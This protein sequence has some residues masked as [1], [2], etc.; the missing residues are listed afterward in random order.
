MSVSSAAEWSNAEWSNHVGSRVVVR[1]REDGGFRDVLGELLAVDADTLVV[2]GRGGPQRLA[3]ADV[4]AGKPV[5]PRAT[6]RAPA[7]LGLSVADLELV[8]AKHWQ[9][10][11]QEWLGGWLLRADHGFTR[12]ANSVLAIGEPGMQLDVAALEVWD[13][14]HERGL[15]PLAAAPRPNP[16]DGD[17]EQLLTAVAAF[18]A[19]G[20]SEIA[21]SATTVLTAATADLASLLPEHGGRALPDGFTLTLTDAPDP[22]WLQQYRHHGQAVPTHGVRLLTSAPRQVFVAVRDREG[23]SAGVARGSLAQGWVGLTSMHV[24]PLRRRRGLALAMIGQIADWGRRAGALSFFLQ[25]E[26]DNAAALATYA[27]A[28][29]VAHHDY[30]YLSGGSAQPAGSA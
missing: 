18:T 22:I 20:W 23:Q 8:M 24:D 19:A 26:Q 3:L 7:H 28:G 13:W 29:M 6:R 27:A 21:G 10:A 14:Y 5:P 30:G 4:V 11:E 17:G 25:V 16:D 15:E 1:I 2:E 9:A 12:R